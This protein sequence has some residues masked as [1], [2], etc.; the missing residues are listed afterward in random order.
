[1]Q[2]IS[3]PHYSV[4]QTVAPAEEPVALDELKK[5]C[6]VQ[7]AFTDDDT[8][9]AAFLRDAREAFEELNGLQLVTATWALTLDG[10]GGIPAEVVLRPSPVLAVSGVSYVDANGVTQT[11]GSS[12]YS[13]D[14]AST[15]AR[16]SL[17]Y[18][19]SWPSV[20]PQHSAVTITF[21]AGYGAAS[22]VPERFKTRIKQAAK[23]R[24]DHRD[25]TDE[26]WLEAFLAR[27]RTGWM[28]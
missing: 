25:Q 5:F 4:T 9:L 18:G 26:D 1:M 3:E 16:F 20:R 28:F 21:T 13:L 19:E 24:Y 17:A 14:A 7:S 10:Y 2:V 8:I 6:W 23:Y 11:A 15:P 12:L 27:H 22:A